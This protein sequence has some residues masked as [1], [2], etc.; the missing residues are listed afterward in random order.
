VTKSAVCTAGIFFWLRGADAKP[1]T[2][3]RFGEGFLP[4]WSDMAVSD[5]RGRRAHPQPGLRPSARGRLP[6]W[7]CRRPPL[8]CGAPVGPGAVSLPPSFPTAAHP[9]ERASASPGRPSPLEV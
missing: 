7:P 8:G 5:G 3:E 6:P 4:R 1:G 9:P 2:R